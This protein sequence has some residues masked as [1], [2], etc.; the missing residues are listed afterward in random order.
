[1]RQVSRLFSAD[2]T[3]FRVLGIDPGAR[4]IGLALS[5]P[6]ALTAQGLETFVAGGKEDFEDHLGGLI[7]RY[8][9]KTVVLGL[10]LSMKGEEIEGSRRSRALAARIVE[11]FALEVVLRDERMTSLEAEKVLRS[12]ERGFERRD[13]DKLS[14]V[15]LLQN[16]LDE[17]SRG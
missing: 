1:M 15:L 14:A 10:P 8:Q 2:D 3:T 11:R 12:G 17:R 7:A 9:I 4:R 6:L 13:I 5:D 16:Y